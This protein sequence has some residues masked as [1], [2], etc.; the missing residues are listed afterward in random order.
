MML[1]AATLAMELCRYLQERVLDREVVC[2]PATPFTEIGLDSMSIIELVMYL[3]RKH[4]IVLPDAALTP[5]NLSSAEALASCAVA[6]RSGGS[7]SAG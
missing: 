6:V 2:S 3:E 4:G 5:G 1:D 7:T